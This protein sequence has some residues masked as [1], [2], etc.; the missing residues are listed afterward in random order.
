M[1]LLNP[2]VWKPPTRKVM[3]VSFICKIIIAKKKISST[4]NPIE[5]YNKLWVTFVGNSYSLVE[6]DISRRERE[7]INHS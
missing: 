3:T 1:H 5:A 4:L 6:P 7:K 2:V